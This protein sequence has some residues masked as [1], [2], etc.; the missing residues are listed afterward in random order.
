M[1]FFFTQVTSGPPI[2]LS[3]THD[4]ES[5]GQCTIDEWEAKRVLERR[6]KSEFR[7]PQDVRTDWLIQSGYSSTEVWNT[8]LAIQKEKQKRRSSVTT[9]NPMHDKASVVSENIRRRLQRAVGKRE[10]SDNL[11]MKWKEET[12][13]QAEVVNSRPSFKRCMTT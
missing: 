5:S 4:E 1:I 8:V 7:V 11:Y 9:I 3:W 12:S 10:K 6:S 13:G 2:S